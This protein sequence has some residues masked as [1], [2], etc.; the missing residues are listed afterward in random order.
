[1]SSYDTPT[2]ERQVSYIES[3][4]AQVSEITFI[5][6]QSTSLCGIFS[7]AGT[8]GEQRS[9][10]LSHRNA[11]VSELRST[12]WSG[13]SQGIASEIINALKRSDLPL[14][15]VLARK[16]GL[17]DRAVTQAKAATAAGCEARG[18]LRFC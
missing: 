3:L 9:S 12:E 18:T 6:E 1:M 5:D 16:T 4:V 17:F 2:S 7:R 11:L 14:A 8:H 15:V 10:V 13:I